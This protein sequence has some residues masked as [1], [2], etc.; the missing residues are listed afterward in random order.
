MTAKPEYKLLDMDGTRVR[1][2]SFPNA[3]APPV[4]LALHGLT[5]DEDAMSIFAARIPPRYAVV[6]PRGIFSS[7][8]GGYSWVPDKVDGFPKSSSFY[9]SASRIK[10]LFNNT[11]E[12]LKIEPSSIHLIGF[13]QG[14]AFAFSILAAQT[15]EIRS[16]ASLAG[17]MPEDLLIPS[18][19][20]FMDNLEIFIAHG[21]NDDIVPVVEAR[22]A[23][24][25][26]EIAGANVQ[27]CE[28]NVG[29]KLSSDCFQALTQ[30]YQR[31][32]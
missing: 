8:L 23:V 17:F 32:L 9:E 29:H 26:F 12:R 10:I 21:V 7:S 2:R 15:W 31:L 30:F 28:S 18:T 5:G 27:Y 14:A 24:K 4:V 22:K 11:L 13:S 19:F 20:N 3:P 25:T 16:V 1:V 6:L